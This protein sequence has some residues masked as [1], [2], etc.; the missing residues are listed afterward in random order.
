[1][2]KKVTIT[3]IIL[4]F[5]GG[6]L[7]YLFQDYFYLGDITKEKPQ[8]NIETP[9]SEPKL[10]QEEIAQRAGEKIDKTYKTESE[11][12]YGDNLELYDYAGSV[13]YEFIGYINERDYDKAYQMILEDYKNNNNYTK[14]TLKN[15]FDF[16]GKDKGVEIKA[17]EVLEENYLLIVEL[18]DFEIDKNVGVVE[19]DGETEEIT[20]TI[21]ENRKLVPEGDITKENTKI[22]NTEDISEEVAKI[23]IVGIDAFY[24]TYNIEITGIDS[25]NKNLKLAIS[26][27]PT[28]S[29]DLKKPNVNIDEYY[30][31]NKD[32]LFDLYGI[33]VRSEFFEFT[34][35]VKEIEVITKATVDLKDA[36]EVGNVVNTKLVVTSKEKEVKFNLKIVKEQIQHNKKYYAF[37]K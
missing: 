7:L 33:K 3:F 8:N 29:N 19:Y 27:L 11:L 37:I 31:I 10:S 12:R 28:I 21:Y 34:K 30:N 4:F 25:L 13:V 6:T 1:M 18:I 35:K 9:T 26:L 36:K 2:R 5:I 14:E 20:F 15:T 24:S 22:T 17:F 23:N 32:L 16:K